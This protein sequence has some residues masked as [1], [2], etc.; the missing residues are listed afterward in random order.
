MEPTGLGEITPL[1]MTAVSEA[2]GVVGLEGSDGV[3]G[4]VGDGAGRVGMEEPGVLI[5]GVVGTEIGGSGTVGEGVRTTGGDG[6]LVPVGSGLDEVG[7][8]FW[9]GR[10]S[11][12]GIQSTAKECKRATM[13]A[14]CRQTVSFITVL[15]FHIG[16]TKQNMRHEVMY[17][18]LVF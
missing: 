11:R 5:T 4:D 6:D 3:V 16:V 8:E 17:G 13:R 7:T 2:G 12:K 18:C 10:C 15:T 14:R 1:R 9:L